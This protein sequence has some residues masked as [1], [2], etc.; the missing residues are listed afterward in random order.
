MLLALFYQKLF[1]KSRA[2][3]L[4]DQ[5]N[6][7]RLVGE[8]DIL[9]LAQAKKKIL[10]QGREMTGYN[11]SSTRFAELQMELFVSNQELVRLNNI[12]KAN[13]PLY[14]QS[15]LDSGFITLEDVRKNILTDHQAL[16]EIFSGDSA[17][18]ALIITATKV[19]LTKIDKSVLD[20]TAHI[21]NSYLSNHDFLNRDFTGF[22]NISNQLY[23]L[24]FK[25]NP[26]P[27]GRIIISPDG[28]YFPFEALVT[29]NTNQ[30]IN[31]FLN[32]HAVS[33]TYSAR[34]L[35]NHFKTSLNPSSRNFMGLAPVQ[36]PNSFHLATLYG[37]DV[38]L[39]EIEPYFNYADVFTLSKASKN[40]FLT[41]FSK[42]KI[43]QL[44]THSS[45]SGMNGEPVIW[46]ADSALY[47]SD[48]I[49]TDKPVTDLIVLSACETGSGKLYEGEG[50]FSFNRGFAALG[51]PSSI[52]NLWS[53]D[54]LSTYRLTELFYKYLSRGIPIDV[55]L[56]KA[57]LEFMSGSKENQLPYYWAAS[58]LAGKTDAINI[59][60]AFSWKYPIIFFC[61][62]VLLIW[63][64]ADWAKKRKN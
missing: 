57:K 29:S 24:I 33:Y 30:P 36:Y 17:V 54:N 12:I 16:V 32:D 9:K 5:L 20:S 28:R 3:L 49:N 46:F 37:S 13:N 1:E 43:I 64:L 38:S 41:D 25:N 23:Q 18:Y 27:A 11:T 53:V 26:V 31:Y 40:N 55:A 6:E 51:I 44:Y 7:Q 19:H 15:F 42:Y 59:K 35:L 45:D 60:K 61:L 52:A 63:G 34:Y 10:E 2:V 47:L 50:I 14:Y 58:I 48:L 62:G 4:N 39:R 56:Q 22:A 8:G 21:F